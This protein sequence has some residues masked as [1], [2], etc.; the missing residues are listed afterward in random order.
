MSNTTSAREVLVKA[1]RLLALDPV[2]QQR[3]LPDFVLVADELANNF[4]DAL[5]LADQLIDAGL[6]TPYQLLRLKDVEAELEALTTRADKRLWTIEA[7]RERQEWKTVRTK[8]LAAL[9]ALGGEPSQ[10]SLTGISYVRGR[11]RE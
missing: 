4:S 1:T 2:S 9:E 5:L 11:R 6:L 7:L 8:A 10:A 3:A